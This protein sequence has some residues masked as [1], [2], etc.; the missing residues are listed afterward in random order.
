MAHLRRGIDE[1]NV[2]LSGGSVGGLSEETLPEDEGSLLGSH[3]AALDQEEVVLDLSVVGEAAH[4]GD[5][6]VNTVRIG[7][8]V[9]VHT[10]VL[11]HSHSVDLLVYSSSVVVPLLTPP[12][13]SPLDTNWMP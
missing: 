6:L 10:P 12:S 4:W 5:V 1:F 3:A 8:S 9:V 13:D 7:H 2:Q 11:T